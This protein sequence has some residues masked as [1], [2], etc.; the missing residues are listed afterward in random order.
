MQPIITKRQFLKYSG[1][2]L[3]SIGVA[4]IGRLSFHLAHTSLTDVPT[5]SPIPKGFIDDASRLNLTKIQSITTIPKSIDQAELQLIELV[6]N[7]NQTNGS[8][9]LAGSKHTMGGHA[10][11]PGGTIIDTSSFNG[12]QLDEASE[13]LNVQSGATWA[14]V[15]EYLDA[16]GFSVQVMQSNNDFSIGGTLSANAHGWQVNQAPIV[17]TVES[18]RLLLAD[19]Q[20][21]TC[22]RTENTELFSLTAGGYGLFGI[23][24]DIRL[25]VVKNKSYRSERI[26]LTPEAFSK[27]F[28]AN[29]DGNPDVDL[30]FARLSI[31][32]GDFLNEVM[33]YT[34]NHSTD[35]VVPLSKAQG[36]NPKIEQLKRLIFRGS[37]NSRYG[38]W[39][40][41]QTEKLLSEQ[42][43]Q[44]SFTRNELL[45]ESARAIIDYSETSTSI[46]HEYFVPYAQF[47]RFTKAM[48]SIIPKHKGDL[49]NVTIRD[50][51]A[52]T[53]SFMNYAP[54]PRFAFVLLFEQAR[55]QAGEQTMQ[56]MTQ[57]LI[58][59]ALK[60]QGSYYLPYRLHA[61]RKQ[62][63]ET[64]PKA[65]SFF[66]LKRQYDPNIIFK[67]KFYNQYS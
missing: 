13:I 2:G 53:D 15:I 59:A 52:D 22:S 45:N 56:R 48:R 3:V 7:A 17:S 27:H 24:L 8:I 43:G 12:M 66:Q 33:V 26:M 58:D 20:I 42:I 51:K 25:K 35:A 55:N 40:R 47:Q 6:K 57:E 64:Y 5:P 28:L 10:I 38:K 41:W 11:A 18:F 29:V 67:N 32:K 31:E 1:L 21:K 54:G 37:V 63:H 65:D 16:K 34:F 19:G 50:V 44:T 61:T 9:A 36:N 14:K 62:F 60:L 49:L 46:L 30:F 39:V 4:F 23:I